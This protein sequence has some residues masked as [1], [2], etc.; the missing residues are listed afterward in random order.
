MLDFLASVYLTAVY[1]HA[2][3]SSYK[4]TGSVSVI[5]KLKSYISAFVTALSV[6]MKI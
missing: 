3:K 1:V 2:K 5:P 6:V 4:P